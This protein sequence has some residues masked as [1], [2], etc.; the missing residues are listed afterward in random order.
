MLATHG[1]NTGNDH[2]DNLAE[3]H[4]FAKRVMPAIH[5]R[6]GSRLKVGVLAFDADSGSN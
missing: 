1:A 3:D 2:A 5:R 4:D 6:S